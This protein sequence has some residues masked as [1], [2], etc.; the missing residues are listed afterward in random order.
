MPKTWTEGAEEEL[1][2]EA[3]V[4]RKLPPEH[5]LT[6]VFI[7][8]FLRE[9][10]LN[11]TDFKACFTDGTGDGGIDAVVKFEQDEVDRIALI[12][13]KR[14]NK[15][16]R[17]E[18]LDIAHKIGRTIADFEEGRSSKYS[19]RLRRAYENARTS[20]ENA[21]LDIL[22]CTSA[23]PTAS[24]REKIRESLRND[25]YLKDYSIDVFYSEDIEDA[26]E[27]ID[28]PREFVDEDFVERD[29]SSSMLAYHQPGIKEPKGYI[30]NVRASSIGRLFVLHNDKGLFAQNLRTFV[31]NKKVDDGIT[32]TIVKA[33]ELFWIKNNGI[34]IACSD[35]RVDGN[36][37]VMYRFSIING[38]QT[39]TKIGKS[40]IRPDKDFLVSCKIIKEDDADQMAAYAEAANAQKPIQDRDLWSNSA[41]QKLL[42]RSFENYQP[43]VYLG[44][45]RGIRAFTKAQRKSRGLR[46]WQQ[47]DNKLYG[48]LVL[49]FHRQRPFVAFSQAGT[50]FS[51]NETYKEVFHRKRDFATEV[52]LLRLHDAFLSWRDDFL[53]SGRSDLQEAIVTQGR[54][55]L[56]SSCALLVKVRRKLVEVSVRN[57]KEEWRR[58]LTRNDIDGPLFTIDG[59]VDLPDSTV[60]R[61]NGLFNSLVEVQG[62]VVESDNVG[63]LYKSEDF[64]IATLT[65]RL[66]DR[67]QDEFLGRY[68]REALD[69]FS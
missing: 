51:S 26:I 67:F 48:Q 64:H 11:Q 55:S 1:R 63:R 20:T 8:Y 30:A 44:I 10:E 32:D 18:I 46:D 25:N 62:S 13:S 27:T 3:S 28:R 68:L 33:P 59:D 2:S 47:L 43:C 56:I 29:M 23:T 31:R 19:I 39:A 15:I 34:T 52:D 37:I 38:C 21:P 50:I 61:L 58:E 65:P 49:A 69:A 12:Q 7:K 6:A 45:K 16:D 24:A 42:K 5:L 17:N 60:T 53:E 41:E 4:Y 54:F 14:V 22:I 9:G 66:I 36:R 40:D 35:C 57:Q